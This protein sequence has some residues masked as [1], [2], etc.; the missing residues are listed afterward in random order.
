M[1][2]APAQGKVLKWH[3]SGK[4]P[5]LSGTPLENCLFFIEEIYTRVATS[6]LRLSVSISYKLELLPLN[7]DS[8][9]KK[10]RTN[11]AKYYNNHLKGV[12]HE[13]FRALF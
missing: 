1:K 11:K 5:K 4:I 8:S 12:S 13:I 3:V 2:R 6:L 7:L 10:T 9:I